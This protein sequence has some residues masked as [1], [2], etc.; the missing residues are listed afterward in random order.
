[1]RFDAGAW[2]LTVG[3]SL[4]RAAVS[5][6]VTKVLTQQSPDDAH[7]TYPR[8]RLM[9]SVKCWLRQTERMTYEN[10][11][12]GFGGRPSECLRSSPSSSVGVRAVRSSASPRS[13]SLRAA[14]T[15]AAEVPHGA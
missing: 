4:R 2:K 5:I 14:A 10:S 11:A 9:P 1:M 13:A 15:G 6:E 8:M 3:C 12:R 7:V